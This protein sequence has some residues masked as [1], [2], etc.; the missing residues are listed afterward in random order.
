MGV[1]GG[2]C[3]EGSFEK[4]DSSSARVVHPNKGQRYDIYRQVTK[5]CIKED[6]VGMM[7]TNVYILTGR[8][9]FGGR[10]GG[11][12]GGRRGGRGRGGRDQNRSHF[13]GKKTKFE[14]DNG[15]DGKGLL[16]AMLRIWSSTDG[17]LAVIT[18]PMF[19]VCFSFVPRPPKPQEESTRRRQC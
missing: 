14:D 15:D 5:Q 10:G 11:R 9:K 12:G 16:F 4:D 19:L 3:R 6:L 7:L 8:E 17:L 2:R 18:F 1:A 13:Q